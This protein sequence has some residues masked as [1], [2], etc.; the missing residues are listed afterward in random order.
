MKKAISVLLAVIMLA[1][2]CAVSAGAW[3]TT[4]IFGGLDEW[5]LI[6]V[7]PTTSGIHKFTAFYTGPVDAVHFKMEDDANREQVAPV[8]T[9]PDGVEYDLTEGV[10]Y[11]FWFTFS[12]MRSGDVSIRVVWESPTGASFGTLLLVGEG[13]D[14]YII[15][16]ETSE[17]YKLKISH[18]GTFDVLS[19]QFVNVTDNE[20]IAAYDYFPERADYD[21]IAGK[22][23]GVKFAISRDTSQDV[24]IKF[25]PTPFQWWDDLPPARLWIF[26]YLMFGWLLIDGTLNLDNTFVAWMNAL[27]QRILT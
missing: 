4:Y 2:C 8:N 3:T 9:F 13:G 6:V 10:K 18:T 26:R 22:T 17:R 16:P 12:S 19:Y 24:T 27:C 21:L 23:Y 1:G 7:T 14:T 15:W 20:V 11:L 5:R 25:M